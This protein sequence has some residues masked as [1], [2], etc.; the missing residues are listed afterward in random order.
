MANWQVLQFT[1]NGLCSTLQTKL[2]PMKNDWWTGLGGSG[3]DKLRGGDTQIDRQ[4]KKKKK[5]TR[6]LRLGKCL[7][8]EEFKTLH[9]G[10]KPRT[11]ITPSISWRREAYIEETLDDFLKE[12]QQ[13]K[14]I[15]I[16]T[17]SKAT[18]ETLLM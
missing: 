8:I 16:R 6:G 18:L 9:G 14:Q 4:T 3:H 15:N 12:D 5:I 11:Y 2:W 7:S 10:T 1:G 13:I 17:V